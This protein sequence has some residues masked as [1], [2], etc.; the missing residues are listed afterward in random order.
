M[1]AAFPSVC[2]TVAVIELADIFGYAG[3]ITGISFMLPQVYRSF[4][5]KRVDDISWG[6]LVLFFLNCIF[7]LT[8]G[9]LSSA[10]PVILTNGIALLVIILQIML[11]VRYSDNLLM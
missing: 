9:L 1:A 6:M 5:T 10:F 8:Y 4:K 3:T 11:K 2:Y 7:W